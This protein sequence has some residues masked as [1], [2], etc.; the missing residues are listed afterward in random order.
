MRIFWE[1][2]SLDDND[3]DDNLVEM[4][5]LTILVEM[6]IGRYVEDANSSWNLCW[7]KKRE[8]FDLCDNSQYKCYNQ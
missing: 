7:K 5:T 8:M 3:C 2:S 4:P 6:S 1:I